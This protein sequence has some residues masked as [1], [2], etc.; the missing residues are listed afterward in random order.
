MINNMGSI[1]VEIQRLQQEL[2]NMTIEVSEGEGAIRI[3][4][5]GQ[6]EV[7]DVQIDPKLLDQE[8]LETLRL[9]VISAINRSI[10]ESKQIIKNE[11][12]KMTGGLNIPNIPGLF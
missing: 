2:K 9:M 6:Q 12:G 10:V 3:T 8:H 5:N 4:I 11:I 1:I 7:L